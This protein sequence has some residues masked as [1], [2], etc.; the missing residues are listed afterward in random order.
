MLLGDWRVA[1]LETTIMKTTRFQNT[2]CGSLVSAISTVVFLLASQQFSDA[3]IAELADTSITHGKTAAGFSYM[4]GG[5]TLAEQQTMEGRSA[6]Y[7][8]KIVFASRGGI[9]AASIL[10]VIGDN[11]NRRMDK[12]MVHRPW[13]YIQL[14]PGG[15][16]IMARI[17][18]K[19]VL[20]RDVYLSENHRATYVV[21]EH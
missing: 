18:N 15:Y 11:Q 17:K 5:L 13:F 19:I 16:T 7:N 14:P 4:N 21:R 1:S 12:I 8:L 9:L 3:R 2:R 6:S 10:L 20:I